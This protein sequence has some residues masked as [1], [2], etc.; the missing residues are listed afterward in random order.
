ML[1]SLFLIAVAVGGLALTP[2]PAQAVGVKVKP[3]AKFGIPPRAG[4]KI[5]LSL[6]DTEANLVANAAG[7]QEVAGL[8]AGQKF[9][10]VAANVVTTVVTSLAK[11]IG[12]KNKGKGVTVEIEYWVV[13]I[14][15]QGGVKVSTRE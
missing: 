12:E 15:T 6:N 13:P 10:P 7:Q 2:L 14:L 8:L 3:F 5:V 1:R 9:G 4:V 11:E